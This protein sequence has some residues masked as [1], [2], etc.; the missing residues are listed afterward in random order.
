M[1]YIEM[2][3]EIDRLSTQI[4]VLKT[5]LSRKTAKVEEFKKS[6]M[7]CEYC[8]RTLQEEIDSLQEQ[9]EDLQV[10]NKYLQSQLDERN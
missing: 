4:S 6:F 1:E 2:K 7:Y 5:A 8:N 10:N 9:L 3:K